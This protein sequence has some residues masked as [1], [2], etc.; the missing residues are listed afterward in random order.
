MYT[1]RFCG[2]LIAGIFVMAGCVITGF[3]EE[4]TITVCELSNNIQAYVGKVIRVRGELLASRSAFALG[5][6]NCEY[7][8]ATDR[9][10]AI[11]LLRS[12]LANPPVPALSLDRQAWER[13]DKLLCFLG[14][15]TTQ[16]LNVKISATFS[17]LLL[18]RTRRDGNG[19]G[20]QAGG[21]GSLGTF[22]VQLVYSK[23]GDIQIIQQDG[24]DR[25]AVKGF[26]KR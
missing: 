4:R 12:D 14:T 13:M 15:S 7:R 18:A 3:A 23:V 8:G 19:Q 9:I 25:Q 17:G 1:L 21:F 20:F 6:M 2:S 26:G 10:P 16:E 24:D 11:H 5:P 22:S